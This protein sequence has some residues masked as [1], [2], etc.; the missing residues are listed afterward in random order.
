[1]SV[2]AYGDGG[3]EDQMRKVG[4]SKRRLA[5]GLLHDTDP[6]VRL[7]GRLMHA[8]AVWDSSI[9]LHQLQRQCSNVLD[10]VCLSLLPACIDVGPWS[11]VSSQP[12]ID[13]AMVELSEM[14]WSPA[15]LHH[16]L[17]YILP[18]HL[19]QLTFCCLKAATLSPFGTYTHW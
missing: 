4:G 18:P 5:L 6:G 11:L 14:T 8:P 1:M 9:D 12:P 15:Q 3:E 17:S 2:W 7:A 13:M 10:A 19:Y 16:L